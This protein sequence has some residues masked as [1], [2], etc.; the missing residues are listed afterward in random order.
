MLGTFDVREIHVPRVQSLLA[1]LGVREGI[2]V[3]AEYYRGDFR[4]FVARKESSPTLN[5]S[6]RPLKEL[7]GVTAARRDAITRK[8]G[9]QRC[10]F[11]R[12]KRR[13]AM[14]FTASE[15]TPAKENF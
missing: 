15:P 7:G 13:G 6:S 3:P 10:G 14:N 12:G 8:V 4:Y 1:H 11:F 5:Y 9:R 2:T